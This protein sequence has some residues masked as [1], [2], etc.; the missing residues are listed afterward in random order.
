[1]PEPHDIHQ[2]PRRDQADRADKGTGSVDIAKLP[3]AEAQLITDM[4]GEK[5]DEKRLPGGGEKRQK[6]PEKQEGPLRL[7]ERKRREN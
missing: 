2:P 5:R 1:M 6:E 4:A 3:M 7:Q